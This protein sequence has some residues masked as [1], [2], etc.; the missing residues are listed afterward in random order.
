M[1]NDELKSNINYLHEMIFVADEFGNDHNDRKEMLELFNKIKPELLRL[2][3]A[4]EP[5]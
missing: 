5:L 2:I 1:T 3:S 4:K